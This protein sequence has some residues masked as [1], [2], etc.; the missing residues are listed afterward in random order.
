MLMSSADTSVGETGVVMAVSLLEGPSG[1]ADTALGRELGSVAVMSAERDEPMS[2]RATAYSPSSKRE[3]RS[4][5]P[6]YGTAT[7]V[8]LSVTKPSGS[9]IVAVQL[10]WVP[11]RP[12]L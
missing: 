7:A 3:A 8:T 1:T 10:I 2:V 5:G 9:S 12:V 4:S 6:L 11:C